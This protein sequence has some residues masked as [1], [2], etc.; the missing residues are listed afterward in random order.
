MGNLYT[1]IICYI[2]HGISAYLAVSGYLQ[3]ESGELGKIP[4][5]YELLSLLAA[6]WVIC[7][8]LIYF[9]VR[10]GGQAYQIGIT[11]SVVLILVT[12]DFYGAVSIDPKRQGIILASIAL[13]ACIPLIN[14]MIA[15]GFEISLSGL[16]RA[17][18]RLFRRKRSVSAQNVHK[19]PSECKSAEDGTWSHEKEPDSIKFSVPL[20]KSIFIP[21]GRIAASADPDNEKL[22]HYRDAVIADFAIPEN[23]RDYA[24]ELFDEGCGI[25]P[26]SAFLNISISAVERYGG[27]LKF[28]IM[29]NA[30]AYLKNADPDRNKEL[31]HL[32]ASAY[33]ITKRDED[34]MY[35]HLMKEM[36][37]SS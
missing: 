14:A 26:S 24:G 33:R 28:K 15:S 22:K 23:I 36:Q 34:R 8:L 11:Y 37:G 9:T 12:I 27:S 7:A 32:L 2:V 19:T 13:T 5:I 18:N 3:H 35:I 20:L 31:F 10:A 29:K 4:Y 16:K 6:T 17:V 21:L 25:S 1:Y 30:A